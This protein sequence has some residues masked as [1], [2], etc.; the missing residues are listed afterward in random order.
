MLSI[1]V[2]RCLYGDEELGA[3]RVGT[4]VGH[5]KQPFLRVPHLEVLVFKLGTVNRLPSSAIPPGEVAALTH[6]SGDDPVEDAS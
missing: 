3:V 5:G 6:E 4:R 2:G 1:Q